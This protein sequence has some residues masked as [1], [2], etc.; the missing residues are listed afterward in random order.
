[1]GRTVTLTDDHKALIATQYAELRSKGMKAQDV[2]DCIAVKW[3]VTTRTIRKYRSIEMLAASDFEMPEPKILLLDIE[4]APNLSYVW[5]HYE[6]NVI[7]HQTEWYML[8]WSIRWLHDK[9]ITKA[10][11][12]YDDYQAGSDN[13]K[14][15]VQE[16]WKYL[17]DADVLVWQNG[18]KFDHKKINTRFIK[19]GIRPPRPYRTV[20]TLKIA[21]KHFAMNSNKLDDLGKYLGVGHKLQ[22]K[23]FE[24]WKGCLIGDAESWATMK[25]YNEQ[26]VELLQNVYLKLLPWIYSHPNVSTMKGLKDGCRNCGSTDI[27]A[28]GFILTATG[29]R[30]QYRC[31]HCDTW[32]QGTHQPQSTIR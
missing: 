23:G 28:D 1:M 25:A 12:D 29:K 26:D 5:G 7:Q 3:G 16:L 21:R 13:D 19:H 30:P 24:L 10:L 31:E 20:D 15:L 27:T 6:Q 17:D 2:E 11:C 32:M 8:S 4:T 18:D 9:P 22:H 14:S